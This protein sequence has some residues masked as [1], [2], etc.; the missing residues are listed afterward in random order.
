MNY[1]DKFNEEEN[2]LNQMIKKISQNNN[3]QENNQL[4]NIQNFTYLEI[5]DIIFQKKILK[6]KQKELNEIKYETIQEKQYET[7]QEKQK[8]LNKIENEIIQK[9]D[10]LFER[11]T[12]ESKIS[13]I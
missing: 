11:K 4:S 1:F 6:E 5:K 10:K 3:F 13:K 2:L 8:E 9:F 12:F 7:I